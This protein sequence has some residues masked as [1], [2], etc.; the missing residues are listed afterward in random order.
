[1]GYMQAAYFFLIGKKKKKI[2][3]KN[4]ESSSIPK[5]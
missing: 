4:M 2:W 3:K 5:K 1:V